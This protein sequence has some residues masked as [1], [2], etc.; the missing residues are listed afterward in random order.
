MID[1]QPPWSEE[2]E[3][4]VLGAMLADNAVVGD[5]CGAL[6]DAAF[7]KEANRRIFRAFSRLN[8]RG[9]AVDAITLAD[10]LGAE[11][12][13]AG[14]MPYLAQLVDSV[15][16]AANVGHY[17]RILHE[18]SL[19]RDLVRAA[20]ET[21]ADA[22][23]AQTADVQAVAGRASKRFL[24][25]ETKADRGDYTLG[26][27]LV[28]PVLD[29]IQTRREHPGE[30]SGLSTGLTRLD[31][32]TSGLHAGELI[33]VAG[34][35]SMGKTA[36]ATDWVRETVLGD[37]PH[38]AGLFSLEMRA[39]ALVMRMVCAEARV[40]YQAAAAGRLSEAH[41]RALA[42]AASR[43]K[44]AVIAI[45]DTPS[46]TT[47]EL[48]S[49]ARRMRSRQGVELIVVDY[50]QLAT[51]AQKTGTR[52]QEVAEVSRTLKAIAKELEVPVVGISQLS[53]QPE[54]RESHRPRLSDLRESGAIEQDADLV[55]FVYRPGF[56]Q[57]DRDDPKTELIVAKQRN[58]PVG[59]VHARFD[60]R[61]MTFVKD[62]LADY[63]GAA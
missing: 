23:D 7:Y 15:T 61:M 10:E 63:R 34:R 51:T 40:S 60:A 48:A 55:L 36:L 50:L 31:D 17:V 19:A 18:K 52:E 14:G 8:A 53:R 35:P 28:F 12:E 22:L 25:L 5:V 13:T 44:Q 33:V 16:S 1:R 20:R 30:L 2:A 6:T 3:L 45:D 4:A 11:L 21:E 43:L 42:E 38:P 58:G 56:Y 54:L 49:R 62:P 41:D 27:D 24:A 46:L 59:T 26:S 9:Q 57:A 37:D 29:E 47:L 39:Q 32:M